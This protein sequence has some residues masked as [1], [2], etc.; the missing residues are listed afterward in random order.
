MSFQCPTCSATL[1]EKPTICPICQ[2][3]FSAEKP[4]VDHTAAYAALKSSL[5]LVRVKKRFIAVL[6]SM[7]MGSLG[8]GYFYIGKKKRAFRTL[9][10][11][12]IIILFSLLFAP[13]F[14]Y[15]IAM[16]GFIHL[17]STFHFLFDLQMKDERGE[18]LE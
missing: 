5:P 1:S 3:T 2:T 11:S 10:L 4:Q 14:W 15:G 6:L 12:T 9:F 7:L 17:F 18:L 13:F 8:L 16:I